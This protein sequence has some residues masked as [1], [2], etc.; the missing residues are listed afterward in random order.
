MTNSTEQACPFVF[1][2]PPRRGRRIIALVFVAFYVLLAIYFPLRMGFHRFVN[3]LSNDPLMWAVLAVIILGAIAFLLRRAYPS[4]RSLARLE[5]RH[6]SIRF[7]PA[8]FLNRFLG[9][10]IL[11][12][13][14]VSTCSRYQLLRVDSTRELRIWEHIWSRGFSYSG[15]D[16]ASRSS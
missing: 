14:G 11:E 7:V 2:V 12:V 10:P 4:G 8:R 9:E 1:T 5:A 13:A 15:L 3:T 16:M 6:D